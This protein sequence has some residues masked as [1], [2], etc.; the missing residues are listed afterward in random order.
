MIYQTFDDLLE[1]QVEKILEIVKAAGV[2]NPMHLQYVD[3]NDLT[4]VLDK[5]QSRMLVDCFKHCKYL[6]NFFIII[7]LWYTIIIS[8]D[9]S[10]VLVVHTNRNWCRSF[11]YTNFFMIWFQSL[12]KSLI[13]R[14]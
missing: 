11:S 3:V 10:L 4:E 1:S 12:C 6:I 13:I 8:K 9:T 7:F 2:K 5:I 14:I